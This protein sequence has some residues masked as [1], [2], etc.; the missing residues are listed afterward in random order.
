MY[1]K[2]FVSI[3]IAGAMEGCQGRTWSGAPLQLSADPNFLS[4]RVRADV[5]TVRLHYAGGAR[6]TL[7]PTRGYV[8]LTMPADRKL[9]SADGLAKDGRVVGHMSFV[10]PRHSSSNGP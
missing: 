4:G 9:V 1:V 10:P 8:L 7:Q 3:H 5:A 6:A 2:H